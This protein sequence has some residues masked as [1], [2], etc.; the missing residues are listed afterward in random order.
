MD[1]VFDDVPVLMA[2]FFVTED[3]P[4][5]VKTTGARL[6]DRCHM[7]DICV[8]TLNRTCLGMN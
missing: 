1:D 7:S 6:V 5:V 8:P 2:A 3:N 4:D